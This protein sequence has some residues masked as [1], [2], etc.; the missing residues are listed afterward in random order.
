MRVPEASLPS[1]DL[2]FRSQCRHVQSAGHYVYGMTLQ[3]L[4]A[5]KR[6]HDKHRNALKVVAKLEP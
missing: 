5:A 6:R 4:L 1:R 3:K 2:E